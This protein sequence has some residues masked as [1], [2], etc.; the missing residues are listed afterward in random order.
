[1]SLTWASTTGILSSAL[2]SAIFYAV[3]CDAPKLEPS[4][5]DDY[6]YGKGATWA[7]GSITWEP[8]SIEAA[9]YDL[10]L[11]SWSGEIYPELDT[12]VLT[13]T[14]LPELQAAT[15]PDEYAAVQT[16]LWNEWL[17]VG[18]VLISLTAVESAA[19]AL[20]SGSLL[21]P[22][23]LVVRVAVAG[24]SI[25]TAAGLLCDAYLLLRFSRASIKAFKRRAEDR[26]RVRGAT[27]VVPTYIAFAVLARLPLFLTLLATACIALLLGAA[28]YALSPTVVFG[29]LILVGN[30]VMLRYVLWV[31]LWTCFAISR[32]W[33]LA[34]VCYTYFVERARALFS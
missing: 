12:T 31:L 34:A 25:A 6:I 20:A 17:N 11:P 29:V 27:A 1:M 28:A 24:A 4:L 15:S 14:P 7:D 5:L 13:F 19:F 10:G 8:A 30:V 18:G 16:Q 3:A 9:S 21:S 33:R 22:T 32:A 2:L 23:N 26:Y